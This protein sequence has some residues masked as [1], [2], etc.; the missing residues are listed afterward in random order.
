MKRILNLAL[1]AFLL[2]AI[3]IPMAQELEYVGSSLWAG[4]NDIQ[5]AGDY[6]YCAFEAG[7]EI[8]DISI[9]DDPIYVGQHYTGR[10]K[11]VF[12]EGNF[13]YVADGWEGLVTID[14]SDPAHPMSA[15][16]LP[17]PGEATDIQVRNG[18][19]YIADYDGGLR[20]IDV[21][22][23]YNPSEA[24]SLTQPNGYA[25]SIF[26]GGDLAYLGGSGFEFMVIDVS[27]PY[28]PSPIG[29][30]SLGGLE[31]NIYVEGDYAYVNY[32]IDEV[33]GY[34]HFNVI[35]ISQA[36]NPVLEGSLGM[37]WVQDIMVTGDLA[38]A[39]TWDGMNVIDVAD[40]DNP[41]VTGQL[42]AEY[43]MSVYAATPL[44]YLGAYRGIL[45]VDISNPSEPIIEGEYFTPDHHQDFQILDNY[46][47]IPSGYGLSI[48]DIS[49]PT[50]PVFTGY[51]NSDAMI[52]AV[53]AYENYA[54]LAYTY[55]MQVIDVSDAN[56][57]VFVRSI[58]A[59]GPVCDVYVSGDYLYVGI[60][61]QGLVI[62][63]LSDP[64]DPH[65][66]SQVSIPVE[67]SC[68][69]IF[70]SGDYAY[71]ATSGIDGVDFHIIDIVDRHNPY[72]SGSLS[73]DCLGEGVFV[74][75]NYAYLACQ[76]YGLKV[77]DI[78]DPTQPEFVG[79][80]LPGL[81]FHIYGRGDYLFSDGVNRAISIRDPINPT[82]VSYFHVP[83]Y[84]HDVFASE[85]Y[86]YGTSDQAF[87]FLRFDPVCIYTP[88]DCNDNG[89]ALELD[90]VLTMIATY[91]GSVEPYH[92]CDCGV[93][94]PGPHFAATA[95]PNGNCIPNELGDV[96]TEMAA[97]RG[98][99]EASGCPDCPGSD[100]LL[101]R[102]PNEVLMP[103]ALKSKARMDWDR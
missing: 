101:S 49:D 97:Y 86:V 1:V 44:L 25:L 27:D 22:D 24:G 42:P 6:A 54:Y 5:V 99:A 4:A 95:D 94:P 17:T 7:L 85:D 52:S 15:G 89:V 41:Q 58:D 71:L 90:D 67:Y 2:L 59:S 75:G 20:I 14:I 26:V 21:S 91:R 70:V 93:D 43:S 53:A 79:S 37:T 8:F 76:A 46:A 40:P 12:V 64:S 63:D 11:A 18:F 38:Y 32:E 30:L 83:G 82:T 39:A 81:V 100:R 13:A 47:Y 57:P 3:K 68:P 72:I 92:I 34:Y 80:R 66:I 84:D 62:R 16:A 87:I 35:N 77:V 56:D 10:A 23:P 73:G 98:T 33:W 51:F 74:S 60:S 69:R 19:A 50:N 36:E 103:P 78:S 61:G 28:N 9:S 48:V 96:M 31:R 55:G 29:Q 65:Y 45:T 88:G 102:K